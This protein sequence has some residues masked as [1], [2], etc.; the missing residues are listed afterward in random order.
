MTNFKMKKAIYVCFL[1]TILLSVIALYFAHLNNYIE[2]A[3]WIEI[4]SVI[5]W[6]CLIYSI[7]TWKSLRNEVLCLYV[8]YLILLYLFTFGQS[9]LIIFN[10]VHP[11][12]SL[13]NR[14]AITQ[15]IDAQ[16]FTLLSLISFHLGALVICKEPKDKYRRESIDRENQPTEKNMVI[17]KAIKYTGI[18]LFF[19]SLPGLIYN[20]FTTVRVVVGGGYGAIYGYHTVPLPQKSMAVRL[21]QETANYYI[22]ALICLLVAYRSN[23]N[24][25]SLLLVFFA[26]NM[27]SGLYIGGRSE[28][29]TLF[30]IIILIFHY[31]I[32]PISKTR[33]IQMGAF[34]YA[35]MS[36]FSVVA[37]LRGQANRSFLD[38]LS[39]FFES[40]GKESLFFMTISEIGW[41]MFPLCAVMSIV[42]LNFDFLL[43][44]SYLYA[45]ISVIPNFGFW[46]IHPAKIYCGGAQWL[47]D[48]LNLWSGPGFT[49]IADAYR[50][51]G[52]WGF[53]ALFGFGLLFGS[54]YSSVNKF[55]AYEKPDAFCIIMIFFATTLI[56]VRGDNLSIA[57]PFYYIVV[58][59]YLLIKII[60]GSL[61]RRNSSSLRHLREDLYHEKKIQNRDNHASLY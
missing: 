56:S 1:I 49:L 32:N 24:V 61:K 16:F 17:M 25:R 40:F 7:L 39:V 58:P 42:P 21:F 2:E 20:T 48:T 60:Y 33:L 13:L 14:L 3:T 55:S 57:R 28:A 5:G 50:N 22:P 36:F 19:L 51:F 11:A 47:M 41:T 34:T 52:W 8:V 29:A 59:V 9:L 53:I 10:L 15:L 35:F 43:G 23:K 18:I 6:I 31:T 4:N 38:Y 30:L 54:L 12:K 27:I 46:E 45:F 44:K 26:I 37:Q